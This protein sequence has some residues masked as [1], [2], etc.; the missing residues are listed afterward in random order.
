MANFIPS[1]D[2]A[3]REKMQTCFEWQ[4]WLGTRYWGKYG[5]REEQIQKKYKY[6]INKERGE[7][8]RERE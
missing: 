3:E 4:H 6:Y 8:K 2:I 5:W 7:I 1:S